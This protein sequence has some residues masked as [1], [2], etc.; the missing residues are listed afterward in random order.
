QGEVFE[1]SEVVQVEFDARL[2]DGLF[3]YL[4]Q[5]GEQVRPADPIIE[6]LTL[7]AA[8]A[9]VPFVV[10]VPT[11]ALDSSREAFEV[12]YHPSGLRSP[13]SHLTLMHRGAET[14]WIDQSH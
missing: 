11:R 5:V 6:R 8:I 13:R 7:S 3:T 10:L 4:P 14:F 9:R 1:M 2:D 12:M